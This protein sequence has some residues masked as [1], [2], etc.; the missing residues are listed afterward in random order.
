MPA[1]FHVYIL[2]LCDGSHY[3]GLT[4]D[5][6]RRISEHQRGRSKSTRHRLPVVVIHQ[7]EV[8]NRQLARKLEVKIKKMGA[9]RYLSK[10][11]FSKGVV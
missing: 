7:V 9:K 5:I 3:T 8:A 2:R 6:D 11:R 10:L 1:V 4:G